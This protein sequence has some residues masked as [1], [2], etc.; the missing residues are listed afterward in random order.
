MNVSK[1]YSF[2]KNIT[3]INRI[4]SICLFAILSFSISAQTFDYT[5]NENT[6]VYLECVE[7]IDATDIV[8]GTVTNLLAANNDLSWKRYELILPDGWTTFV[9]DINLCYGPNTGE[10]HMEMSPNQSGAFD[11]H[12]HTNGH[13]GDSAVVKLC[14]FPTEDTTQAICHTYT[15]YCE[16]VGNESVVL[17]ELSVFPNPAKDVIQIENPYFS[18][19]D[20]VKLELVNMSGQ[21]LKSNY[22]TG[23]NTSFSISDVP[24]GTYV[25]RVSSDMGVVNRRVILR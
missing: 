14:I 9:C 16:T 22:A 18:Q 3:M 10:R 19:S 12:L 13:P 11:L 8:H 4:L 25:I 21:V 1:F 2:E 20:K 23:E 17:D 5:P 6:T 15:F 7:G 24:S